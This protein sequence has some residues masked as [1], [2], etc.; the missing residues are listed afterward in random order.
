MQHT[1]QSVISRVSCI[2][3]RPFSV[4]GTQTTWGSR[5][6]NDIP[7]MSCEIRVS[8]TTSTNEATKTKLRITSR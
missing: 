4:S 3:Q 1:T 2:A 8:M 7:L 6:E 5:Y